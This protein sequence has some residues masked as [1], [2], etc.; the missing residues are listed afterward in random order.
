[1]RVQ[2]KSEEYIIA[3]E[4]VMYKGDILNA[5]F[6]YHINGLSRP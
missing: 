3:Y 2:C 4:I 5:K 6:I 1:M